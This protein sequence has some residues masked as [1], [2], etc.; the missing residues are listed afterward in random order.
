MY[1]ISPKQ[2]HHVVINYMKEISSASF[3]VIILNEASDLKSESRLST[4][5]HFVQKGKVHERFVVF[6]N[7]SADGYMFNKNC[8]QKGTCPNQKIRKVTVL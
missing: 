5:L 8:C 4:V 1:K 7:V 3:V 2:C 6:T